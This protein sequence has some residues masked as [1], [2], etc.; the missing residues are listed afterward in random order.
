MNRLI[1]RLQGGQKGFTLIELLVVIAI[2]GVIS[3][4]VALNLG[5]FFGRGT[6]Q[7]ANTELH[8]VQTA[9]IAAMADCE[10]GRL[11]HSDPIGWYGGANV[12]VAE[13]GC[14]ASQFVYGPF[15]ARYMVSSNGSI[16]RGLLTDLGEGQTPWTG[17]VW[18]ICNRNWADPDRIAEGCRDDG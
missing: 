15:R 10:T 11:E 3:A 13:G 1:K 7:A 2:L 8:Q 9:I 5:G 17:I 12:V 16:E 14:D 18:D 6:L 4:V